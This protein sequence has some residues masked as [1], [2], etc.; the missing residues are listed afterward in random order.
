MSDI[1]SDEPPRGV[2]AMA[3][4]R[5][6]LVV[7]MALIAVAALEHRYQW[8]GAADDGDSSTLYYCP[9]HPGV[10]QDHPGECPICSMTLVPRPK[11][12]GATAAAA[13]PGAY[14]CPMHPEVTSDDPDATCD[15]CGGMKLVPRPAAAAPASS[16]VPGLVPVT[17][18]PERV[19]LLGM[20]TAA[21]TREAMASELRTVGAVT[22][23][24]TG[25]AVVQIRFAGWIE[26]LRVAQTGQ[27]VAKGQILATV[28]SP[29]L[30]AAQQEHLNAARWGQAPASGSIAGLTAGL[31]EDSRRRL[32]LLGIAAPEIAELERTGQPLRAIPV[33]SPVSGHVIE[34][35]AVQGVYVQPGTA[36]F[37]IANLS[38]VWVIADVYEYEVGRVAVGQ[39]ASIEVA[40]YPGETFTGT[41]TFVSPT[42]ST[43]TRTLRV[44]VELANPGFRLKPGMYGTVRVQVARA[45]ALV[46]PADAVVDTGDTQYVFLAR[47]GGTF[48]P[49]RVTVGAR[50]GGKAQ[51]V[52]GLAA[53]ETVVTTGNFLLDSESHLQAT[54]QGSG[55]APAAAGDACDTDIDR[56]RFPDKHRQCVACRAHRGMGDMEEDCR[57]Q[58]PRPWK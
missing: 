9:M 1:E 26:A 43:E 54:V 2:R 45:D 48:E 19:Q 58:I 17:L 46:V 35:N 42:L 32:E 5:W 57:K 39:P 34:K 29:E 28:Y 4:V 6:G 38:R 40:T 49:R 31:L 10:Q 52:H 18:T 51:I 53:G 13:G 27:R 47:P 8:F 16:D 20:R 7:V 22:T 41:I 33:R 3:I 56:Q 37:Q 55:A 23:A 21:V 30:L 25:L 44:R 12:G 15:R 36:L 11:G 50:A 24:E 14:Y